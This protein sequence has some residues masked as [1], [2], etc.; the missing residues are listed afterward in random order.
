MRGVKQMEVLSV[1]SKTSTE[2][3]DYEALVDKAKLIDE[4]PYLLMA[5]PM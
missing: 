3:L 1:E 2:L 4:V 5:D